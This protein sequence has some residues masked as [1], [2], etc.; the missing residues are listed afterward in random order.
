MSIKVIAI[1]FNNDKHASDMLFLLDHYAQDPMGGGEA[2]SS[3]TKENLAKELAKL[4]HAFAFIAYAEG[5]PAGLITC[6]DGFST[7]ACKPL[8]SIHDIAVHSDFRGRGISQKLLHAVEEVALEKKCCKLTLEVLQGN[9]IA[10]NAYK[11]FGFCAYE[12]D[13]KMGKAEFW[14]KTL[15]S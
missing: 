10:K 9:Q 12:L 15:K 2:L 3:Y 7:F 4:S 1:D 13:P 6:F 8:V 14:Q 11:K 5:E